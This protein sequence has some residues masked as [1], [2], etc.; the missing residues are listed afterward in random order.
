[1]FYNGYISDHFKMPVIK[2][3]YKSGDILS[4]GNYR[5]IALIV[6]AKVVVKA[7]LIRSTKFAESCK[8]LYTLQ[9]AYIQGRSTNRAIYMS[10]DKITEAMSEKSS[11]RPFLDLSK[12]FDSVD[13][14]I[15]LKKKNRSDG[16]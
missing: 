14:V 12:A 16:F 8:L 2:P 5:S 10:I 9:S 7:I 13:H 3:I 15:L 4:I 6:I 11:S 1:M